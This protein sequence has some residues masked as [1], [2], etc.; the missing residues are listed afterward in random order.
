MNIHI[1]E[2]GINMINPAYYL[3]KW[4]LVITLIVMISGCSSLNPL[5]EPDMPRPDMK[6][7]KEDGAFS[8]SFKPVWDNSSG[9]FKTRNM[10][11]D[12]VRLYARS[13]QDAYRRAA[14]GQIS[15]RSALDAALIGTAAA[16][17]AV[18]TTGGNA[19]T[20]GLLGLGA[21][22]LGLAGDRFLIATRKRIW[23]QGTQALECVVGAANVAPT[24][25]NE[26]N[27]EI[28]LIELNGTITKLDTT[29]QDFNKLKDLGNEGAQELSKESF[30]TY[31]KA[32]NNYHAITNVKDKINPLSQILLSKIIEIRLKV[33]AEIV[34]TEPDILSYDKALRQVLANTQPAFAELKNLIPPKTPEEKI[35]KSEVHGFKS[36]EAESAF[37]RMRAAT[38]DVIK[39]QTEVLS[40]LEI[41]LKSYI[42]QSPTALFENCA[43][44]EKI[45]LGSLT[46]SPIS[47]LDLEPNTTTTVQ[48]IIRGG[49][50]PYSPASKDLL[51]EGI[52]V[53]V[54]TSDRLSVMIPAS[55]A[56]PGARFI[57]PVTDSQSTITNFAIGFK[58][59]TK[60]NTPASRNLSP[61]SPEQIPDSKIK[62]IQKHLKDSGIDPGDLDGVWGSKT[63]KAVATYL[64]TEFR[65]NLETK[66]EFK[67]MYPNHQTGQ[68]SPDF[69]E[70]KKEDLIILIESLGV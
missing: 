33:E 7:S 29:I 13:L 56:T 18:A 1:K 67:K 28:K 3:I 55:S 2:E 34:K 30:L 63:K 24:E 10:T 57:V 15:Y 42:N 6:W 50:R 38:D 40:I 26:L 43:Y 54:D 23:I 8:T 14:N 58:G 62:K 20:A 60:K 16:A 47:Q 11:I 19:K 5:I 68:E 25:I 32:Q 46:I 51:P 49:Q 17:I 65:S 48:A 69:S 39:A 59:E 37:Q 61:P 12:E 66:P 27:L 36:N 9:Y 41:V 31:M 52:T 4:G 53:S 44:N 22:S 35:E 70:R 45:G 64:K 21:G